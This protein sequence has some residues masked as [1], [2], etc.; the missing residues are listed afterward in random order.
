MLPYLNA[1]VQKKHPET[2]LLAIHYSHTVDKAEPVI[3]SSNCS[4]DMLVHSHLINSTSRTVLTVSVWSKQDPGGKRV[5]SWLAGWPIL[6]NRCANH[7]TCTECPG[8]A[9]SPSPFE[10][11]LI[12][13]QCWKAPDMH[14]EVQGVIDFFPSPWYSLLLGGNDVQGEGNLMTKTVNKRPHFCGLGEV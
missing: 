12:R 14:T 8:C 11:N 7:R 3:S 9:S 10:V 4:S 1:V 6:I 2:K 5:L 13:F